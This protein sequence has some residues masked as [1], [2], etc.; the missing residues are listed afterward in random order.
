MQTWQGY[1]FRILQ[2]FVTKFCNFTNFNKLFLREFT[3]CL[4]QKYSK[5]LTQVV[6]SEL[7]FTVKDPEVK[8]PSSALFD[9]CLFGTLVGSDP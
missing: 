3:F 2:H 7:A 1:I 6:Y 4:D 9:I 5:S 8:D